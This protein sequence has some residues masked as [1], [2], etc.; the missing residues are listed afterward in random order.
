VTPRASA[1]QVPVERIVVQYKEVPVEKEVIVEKVI[2]KEVEVREIS[3]QRRAPRGGSSHD[4]TDATMPAGARGDQGAGAGGKGGGEDGCAG[5]GGD[6]G[7]A[8]AGGKDRGEDRYKRG[9]L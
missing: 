1:Y 8:R 7:G 4:A 2:T 6:P 9:G 3:D 5:G